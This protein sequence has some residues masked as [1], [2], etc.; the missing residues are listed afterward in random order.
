MEISKIFHC[1]GNTC[2]LAWG[3]SKGF[4]KV[5]SQDLSPSLC[6]AR[7]HALFTLQNLFLNSEEISGCRLYSARQVRIW[8]KDHNENLLNRVALEMMPRDGL[9]LWETPSRKPA[10]SFSFD[11]GKHSPSS[12]DLKRG[13]GAATTLYVAPQPQ[14][15]W[16]HLPFLP[17]PLT[18]TPLHI[19]IFSAFN[20]RANLNGHFL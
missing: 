1:H 11:L 14:I 6:D 17:G 9:C 7:P 5:A 3:F 20:F 10:F 15:M 4:P 12:Q 2:Q 13:L 16:C 19:S 18:D 8:Q